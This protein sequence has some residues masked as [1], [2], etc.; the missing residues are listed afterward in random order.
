VRG[1]SIQWRDVQRAVE[2]TVRKFARAQDGAIAVVFA[3]LIIPMILG[4][5]VAVD[6]IRAYNAHAEMQAELDVALVAA[7][8]SVDKVNKKKLEKVIEDWFAT[9]TRVSSYK[10][11]NVVVDTTE[12]TITAT[13]TA[14][15]PTTFLMVGGIEK[16]DVAVTSQIAGPSTSFLDVYLVLDKSASMML[17]ATLIGQQTMRAALGCEFAC[18]NGDAHT[19]NG[20]NY[21]SNYAFSLDAGVSLRSDVLLAAVDRVLDTIDS[22]DPSG[23]H[24]RVGLY[25]LADTMYEVLAP[26]ASAPKVKTALH[27]PANNLTSAS[28]SEATFFDVAL[29]ELTKLVGT[30]GTGKSASSP[31]KLVIM[32][33]D[34]VQSQRPWVFGDSPRIGPFN[35]AWCNGV[36]AKSITFATIYTTYLAMGFD[37]GYNLTV[38]NT[39]ASGGYATTWGGT[40]RSGVSGGI[41][42]R[43]YLPY[44]MEDCATSSAYY[45]QATDSGEIEGSLEAMFQRYL[46]SVRLTK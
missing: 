8:K 34:G 41:P 42:R 23:N 13:A 3:I 29:P 33:S 24:I 35:P 14:K 17:A 31:L 36:K 22:V 6:Y 25:R 44:A 45:M 5:G 38:G 11:D 1:T 21:S 43:D 2:K 7:I 20:K 28:S 9:Q 10:I 18:H 12:S 26:T 37:G 39:M 40:M 4:V 16:V 15:I 19:V 32:V 46:R 30:N 27:N